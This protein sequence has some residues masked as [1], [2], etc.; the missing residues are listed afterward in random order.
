M[1][2]PPFEETIREPWLRDILA[3]WKNWRGPDGTVPRAAIDPTVLPRSAVQFLFIYELTGERWRCALSGTGIGL[4]AGFD[5]S[6][7]NLEDMLIGNALQ[8]RVKLFGETLT[9]GRACVYSG[10][11]AVVDRPY[12]RFERLLLPVTG[13]SSGVHDA[14]FGAVAFIQNEIGSRMGAH[15]VSQPES[16]FWDED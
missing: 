15:D 16:I 8:A 4:R 10:W 2:A 13:R 6:N 12:V 1:S 9:R 14:L 3:A 11:L 7:R 5:P